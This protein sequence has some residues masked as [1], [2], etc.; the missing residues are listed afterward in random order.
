MRSILGVGFAAM[1][2]ALLCLA[3]NSRADEPTKPTAT[4][5]ETN[6]SVPAAGHSL[7][8]EAF[9]D[10]PRQAARLMQGMGKVNFRVTTKSPEAQAFMSQGVAQLHTFFYFEAERS[11]RQAAKLDPDCAL[12]YWGS[13]MAN[14][15]NPRRARGFLK[16]ARKHQNGISRR[17]RLY[18]DALEPLYKEGGNETARKKEHL[19]GLE[20]LVQEFPD[21][22]DAR[23]WLA[24][25]TWQ[26]GNLTSYQVVD[27]VLDSVMQVEPTH[28]GAHHYRIHLWDGTKPIRAERSAALYGRY[29]PGIAHA[30]HMPGHTYTGLQRY[31]DAAYQQEASA[32][33]DHAYMI[34]DR[35]MPFEI[36]NYSHNNQWLVTSLSHIGRARD[37][38]VVARN[39]VEQPRDPNKNG[40]N[41]GGSPQ[42][43]GRARWSEIL[44]RY[45]LWDDLIAATTSGALDWS[46]VPAEKKQKAY[47]LGLAYAAKG[48]AAKL[49]EQIAALKAVKGVNVDAAT[50]ELEGLE[51]LAKGDVGPAFDRFAKATEMRPEALARAHLKARN[52]GHAETSAATAVAKEPNQVPALAAQVEILQIVGKTKK[53]QV[54]YKKLAPLARF[55]DS[56]TPV[57][58]RL[59]AFGDA[60]KREGWTPPTI[61]TPTD[62]LTAGRPDVAT[63]GPLA[64]TPFPAEPIALPDTQ[65]TTWDLSSR[66]GRQVVVLF[67]LGGKCAH[68]MQQ[69]T[70]FGKAFDALKAMNTDVVA[71][72][73]DDL[74]AT[75]DLKAN[76]DGVKFPMPL[77]PDPKL[78][79]FKA[80]H[81]HDDF[82][83]VPL[84]G[85]FLID[86]AGNV[87]FQ[88]ISAEPFLDVDFIK[89]EAARVDKMVKK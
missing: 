11:F 71:L 40:K 10:G 55:A 24:M 73:T 41:D 64:W 83:S 7:H 23:A 59:A 5:S 70:E 32:R 74:A 35:V 75:K 66:K 9:D 87:R 30:W 51:L 6:P 31:T 45:E 34:R 39:L 67:F 21:D 78:T 44:T 12:A 2:A 3:S 81:A 33:V 49:T 42:R 20:V 68:C 52:F 76:K 4:A 28:P 60:W 15:N 80:Y 50:A 48:D 82:E 79:V 16:E 61:D 62:D 43:N 27:L 19:A 86:A 29:A 46:D 69:L 18:I 26:V 47:T 58:R 25:V 84:H 77:L 85:T 53:A 1:T 13:A 88:R 56:D 38:I 57:M 63:L 65:G 17:E 89:T 36:H 22:I 72:S 8:G 54:A 37:G 14:V